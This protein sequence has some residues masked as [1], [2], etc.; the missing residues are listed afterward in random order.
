MASSLPG[1]KE[2]VAQR[3]AILVLGMHRSGTSAVAGVTRALGATPPRTLLPGDPDNARGYWESVPLIDAADDLLASIDSSWDDWR[4]VD[5]QWCASAE[6]QPF[7]DRF[8][9]ILKSE[10]GDDPLF[11]VKD[12]RLCRLLPFFLSVLSDMAIKPIALVPL[13]SPIEVA[14][15]LRRRNGFSHSKS[16]ALWLRHVFDAE[17]YSRGMPRSIVCYEDL[18]A[19]WRLEMNKA[20]VRTGL[21]WPADPED[22]AAS[23]QE[24]L[25]ADLHHQ[26]NTFSDTNLPPEFSFLAQEVH[27]LLKMISTTGDDVD[28][29][30][31]IDNLHSR[32]SEA[33]DFFGMIV[34]TEKAEAKK[35]RYH[36]VKKTSELDQQREA[37]EL[38]ERRFKEVTKNRNELYDMQLKMESS[39][40]TIEDLKSNVAESDAFAARLVAELA[41]AVDR[42][43]KLQSELF[44]KA[45]KIDGMDQENKVYKASTEALR[46]LVV[47]REARINALYDSRSWRLTAIFRSLGR[48]VRRVMGPF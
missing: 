29:L 30:S 28:L 1:S 22:A 31:E 19:D 10:F 43:D 27:R 38:Q 47:E 46:N 23:I 25:G 5:P 7:R 14:F 39:E 12:P 15:S 16:V 44:D 21:T 48:V 40:R 11:V 17:H 3:R 26:K 9:E 34:E 18:L 20:A 6:A 2:A 32:F 4:Q 42:G 24:F 35:L 37:V 45:R 13:R 41:S 8:R 33:S 36:L